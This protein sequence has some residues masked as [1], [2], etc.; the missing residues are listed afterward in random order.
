MNLLLRK[1]VWVFVV[2]I[3]LVSIPKSVFAYEYRYYFDGG[4]SMGYADTSA[5]VSAM[6]TAFNNKAKNNLTGFF[7]AISDCVGDGN[8]RLFDG[9]SVFSQ[10]SEIQTRFQQV[11]TSKY[12][13]GGVSLTNCYELA[14]RQ[15]SE[16]WSL[17]GVVRKS[18]WCLNLY[19]TDGSH[20]FR[21]FNELFQCDAALESA[22]DRDDYGYSTPCEETPINEAK[23]FVTQAPSST[24]NWCFVNGSGNEECSFEANQCQI[25]LGKFLNTLDYADNRVCTESSTGQTKPAIS[26]DKKPEATESGMA[27]VWYCFDTTN[28]LK[29]SDDKETCDAQKYQAE[30]DD[31]SADASYVKSSCVAKS[32]ST[33]MPGNS[34]NS[35]ASGVTNSIGSGKPLGGDPHPA[36]IN[37]NGAVYGDEELDPTKSSTFSLIWGCNG[38]KVSSK[39]GCNINDAIKQVQKLI[40]WGF[41]MVVPI[42]TLLFAYAG[43]LYLTASFKGNKNL[44]AAKS[45]FRNTI[46]AFLVAASAWAIVHFVINFLVTESVKNQINT[47]IQ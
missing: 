9:Q 41:F 32:S 10:T 40:N 42:S 45:I 29:C 8:V 13:S 20:A 21:C 7:P 25:D 14:S 47:L 15:A 26:V 27:R 28:G 37:N 34:G 44:A 6:K 33:G 12:P 23:D 43:Y 24:G 2:F 36:K 18:R 1:F 16:V 39:G 3:L 17:K 19:P 46:I 5:C 35:G 31:N 30:M 4:W 22:K 11:C 38:G